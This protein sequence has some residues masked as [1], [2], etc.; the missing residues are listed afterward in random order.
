MDLGASPDLQKSPGFAKHCLCHVHYVA[1]SRVT[2]FEGLQII[3]F[4]E[5]LINIDEN[6]GNLLS[7]MYQN[8]IHIS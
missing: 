7:H 1:T 5:K 3:N 6:V 8:L 4:N 2:S